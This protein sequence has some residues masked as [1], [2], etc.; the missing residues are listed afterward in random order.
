[1]YSEELDKISKKINEAI[2]HTYPY[3]HLE[4]DELFTDRYYNLI[5]KNRIE[6]QYMYSLKDVGRV[7]KGYSNNRLVLDLTPNIPNLPQSNR[8]FWEEL[9]LWLHYSFKKLLLNK[10]S[11]DEKNVKVDILYTQKKSLLD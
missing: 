9:S 4:I 1:M 6:N 5:L 8:D 10:L 11:V 3:T 2:V 7:G